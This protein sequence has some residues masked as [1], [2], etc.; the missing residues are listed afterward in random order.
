[1]PRRD[2]RIYPHRHKG[3]DAR[4]RLSVMDLPRHKLEHLIDLWV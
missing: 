3:H 4:Y 2:F 1:V